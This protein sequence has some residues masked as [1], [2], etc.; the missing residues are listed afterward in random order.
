VSATV[1]KSRS[2]TLRNRLLIA[3]G[4]VVLVA[5]GFLIGRAQAGPQTP[6]PAAAASTPPSE[7]PS[8][9]PT[10]SAV[11]VGGVDAYRPLQVEDAS[12]VSGPQ[13]QDTEDEGG[14]RNA[15]W[16]GNGDYLRFDNVN[17]GGTPPTAV[18]LRVA[19]DLEPGGRIEI[20]VDSAS[21]PPLATLNTSKTGGWQSW[22]TE[23]TEM[24]PVTGLHTLYVTFGNDRPDDFVNLNWLVFRI[25]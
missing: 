9:S 5:A 10:P 23:T 4:V 8:S 19:S 20:R 7:S 14:G 18:N 21:N 15:G 22:R 11:P 24:S 13:L 3:A 25:E 2:R 17:F 6:A 12:E 1:Y 16:I